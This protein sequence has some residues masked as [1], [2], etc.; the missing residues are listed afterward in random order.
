[1][2][3]KIL[4]VIVTMLIIAFV[5]ITTVE[6][7]L[8]AETETT[9]SSGVQ[10]VD[11]ATKRGEQMMVFVVKFIGFCAALISFIFF[12]ASFPTHQT[13]QRLISFFA[14]VV[15]IGIF[16]GPEIIN[17]VLGRSS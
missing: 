3:R 13:E 4:K 9:E 14:L 12:L 11:D 10:V 15:S 5:S 2:K 1:M 17:A 8:A 7:V 6:P 16:F